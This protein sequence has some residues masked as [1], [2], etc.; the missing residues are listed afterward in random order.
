LDGP[1]ALQHLDALLSIEKLGGIQFVC[2][3]GHEP[4]AGWMDVFKR[5]Q[6]AGKNI[7]VSIDSGQLRA[8]MDA[9]RPEGVM[10]SLWAGSEDEALAIIQR[11]ARWTGPGRY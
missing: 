2:G 4:A 1:N 7:H 3:F 10:L 9:L 11:V 5:I 6:G 8:F